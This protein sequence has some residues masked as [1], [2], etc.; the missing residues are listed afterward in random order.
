MGSP[1]MLAD[2]L[3][4]NG[5]IYWGNTTNDATPFDDT[6]PT[7]TNGDSPGSWTGPISL[8]AGAALPFTADLDNEWDTFDTEM[9]GTDFGLTMILSNGCIV[10]MPPH[11]RPL[12]EPDCTKYS[13][14]DF[15]Y[16]AGAGQMEAVV[17]NGD[18]FDTT[19]TS[20][21]ID[22]E[23]IDSLVAT[24]GDTSTLMDWFQWNY[25]SVWG[26]GDGGA[27]D[28]N[29]PTDTGA[30]S[31]SSWSGPLGF[32]HTGNYSLKFDLDRSND[33]PVN[34]LSLFGVQSSDIG[35]HV[36][37]DNGC[38]L[39]RPVT[40]THVV[41]PTPDCSLINPQ[42]PRFGSANNDFRFNVVNNNVA[43]AYLIN[44]TLIWPTNWGMYFNYMSFDGFTYYDVDFEQFS[45][46]CRPEPRAPAARVVFGALGRRLQQLAGV[47]SQ[48]RLL[49]RQAGLPVPQLG[50][51]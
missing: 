46:E 47:L 4:V 5:A 36:V 35:V 7:D 17:T 28:S 43:T 40:R 27:T 30:D 19:V 20:I 15:G 38:V 10:I 34:W 16:S 50:H 8:W 31:P 9:L 41:T 51:L 37:F 1:N 13:I 21:A 24:T 11:P 12:P 44:S 2:W 25:S 49:Q 48:P 3:R 14:S 26:E 45:G 32:V 23:N 29:S 42:N 39:D 33:A 22:W 6:S 18:R